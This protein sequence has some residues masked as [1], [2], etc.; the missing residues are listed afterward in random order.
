[1]CRVL[2][3]VMALLCVSACVKTATTTVGLAAGVTKSA[4]KTTAGISGDVV[5]AA[6]TGVD[7]ESDRHNDDPRPFDSTR[8]AMLDVEAALAA[9]IRSSRHVLLVLGGNWCHDSR[10]L[11][12]KFEGP[13]L[14]EVLAKGYELVWVDVGYRDRNLDV[15]SRFGVV[16]MLGTPTVLILS[17]E[18]ALLNRDSVH[19]WRTA[20]SKSY[21]ETLA[22]FERFAGGK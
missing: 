11:A 3:L 17:P 20:D 2:M 15:A 13:E 14:A 1:M 10:G 16:E 4:V 8:N 6:F 7:Q 18:G 12:G 22:Y 5:E 9:A 19:D 21:D